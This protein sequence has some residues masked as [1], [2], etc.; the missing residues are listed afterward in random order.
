L[1]YYAI[2]L[3]LLTE[4]QLTF[5]DTLYKGISK[6]ILKALEMADE[7][8]ESSKAIEIL[9]RIIDPETVGYTRI[10]KRLVRETIESYRVENPLK[11]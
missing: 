11:S 4:Y 8:G 9:S 7:Q 2:Q 1:Y 5:T 6:L 10:G 3:L